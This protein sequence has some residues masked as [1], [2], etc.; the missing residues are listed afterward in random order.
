MIDMRRISA[1]SLLAGCV[2]VAS[3]PA[4]PQSGE[5]E[6]VPLIMTKLPPPN[7]ALYKR[8]IKHAG[9]AKGQVLTLTKTEMW[10]VPKENVDAV[11]KA[12]AEHGVGVNP[13]GSD[14][15]QLFHKA[16]TDMSMDDKQKTMM[17][18][19]KASTST[20]G[21]GMMATPMAPMVEYALTKDHND[22]AASRNPAR[23][24][25]AVKEGVVLTVT[26]SNVD[27]KPNM[28]IW[29]GTVDGTG[30]P[31][32]IMWWPGGKMTGTLQHE[33]RIYSFRH[34]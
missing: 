14:W 26:R 6:R 10:A 8:I 7:S 25:I 29:R 16:P 32:T 2:T 28:C 19:A 24:S 15:N 9:K 34:M 27:V 12:A 23:I 17:E 13:L 21:V 3:V 18:K 5:P 31:V 1:L 33:G 22:P 4:W 30:A 20:M 11:K